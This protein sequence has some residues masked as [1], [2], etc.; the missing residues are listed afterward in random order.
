MV[1]RYR[2]LSSFC[3]LLSIKL[4]IRILHVMSFSRF[5]SEQARNPSGLF[6]RFVMSIVFDKGNSKINQFT[7]ELMSVK[8][9]DH[10][11]EIGCGTGKLINEMAKQ[12][13]MGCIE[14]VD[15]SGTMVSI[16][17]RKNKNHIVNGKVKILEGNFDEISYSKNNFHK[18]CSVN[19]IYFWPEPEYTTKKIADILKP[20][21][22]F[23]VA[24]EDIAQLKEKPLSEDVF[25]LY[26]KNDV[27]NLLINA[28]FSS[29]VNVESR[30]VGSSL[31]HCVVGVK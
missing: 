7:V 17:R 16:A 12:I 8:E 19:T 20:Q 28:G 29:G 31:F 13:D 21:G 2:C 23:L 1:G 4:L 25:H 24:F 26:S 9:N 5:F 15:F 14:G 6:G 3:I 11:L 27:K 22:M 30:K 10:I 18:I